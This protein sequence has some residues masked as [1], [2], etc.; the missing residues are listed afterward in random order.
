MLMTV[1]ESRDERV[2]ALCI[3]Y[4][5]GGRGCRGENNTSRAM[6]GATRLRAG[7]QVGEVYAMYAK[8]MMGV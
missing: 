2:W 1:S 8:Q 7:R 3:T 4:G 5:G 6:G